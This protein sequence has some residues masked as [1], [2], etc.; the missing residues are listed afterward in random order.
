MTVNR[1]WTPENGK[2]YGVVEVRMAEDFERDDARMWGIMNAKAITRTTS[3]VLLRIIGA[4]NW[5]PRFDQ[6]N[7]T[8]P[9]QTALGGNGAWTALSGIH[10][11]DSKLSIKRLEVVGVPGC[12]ILHQHCPRLKI[13][14]AFLDR[15]GW[16]VYGTHEP[17]NNFA[18][19]ANVT[20]R[21][22]WYTAAWGDTSGQNGVSV[23]RFGLQARGEL[24][25][26]AEGYELLN[27]T[28]QGDG[29][30]FKLAGTRYRVAGAHVGPAFFNGIVPSNLTT[31]PDTLEYRHIWEAKDVV[32]E[33]SV[34]SG[35]PFANLQSRALVYVSY[36]FTNPL[37]FRRCTFIKGRHQFAFQIN[38]A[39]VRFENCCFIGWTS[40]E[41]GLE[42]SPAGQGMPAAVFS[43]TGCTWEAS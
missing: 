9:W 23:R 41:E 18:R 11:L 36:P 22:H 16:S 32:V 42:L 27:Y 5:H 26:N 43:Q 14:S 30:S 33:E 35:L 21:D 6:L 31:Y 15:T 19:I 10:A 40:P 13:D 24:A 12:A 38:W 37:V 1:A 28:H 7:K 17:D 2:A 3:F 4:P 29:I 20:S 39:S 8:L 34:F 25:Q